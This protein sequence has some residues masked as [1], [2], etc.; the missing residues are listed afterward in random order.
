MTDNHLLIIAGTLFSAVVHLI[1]QPLW[2]LFRPQ[3]R[4]MNSLV[5]VFVSFPLGA[6]IVYALL[7]IFYLVKFSMT[8]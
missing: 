3:A 5:L 6:V 8:P 7:W 1:L 2:Y 4:R